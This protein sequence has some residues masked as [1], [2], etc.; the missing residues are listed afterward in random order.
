M[1]KTTC[2]YLSQINLAAPF[3]HTALRP[4]LV[5]TL[6]QLVQSM[7]RFSSLPFTSRLSSTTFYNPLFQHYVFHI[8]FINTDILEEGNLAE[9]PL[10][11]EWHQTSYGVHGRILTLLEFFLMTIDNTGKFPFTET[12]R[13]AMF[14][15]LKGLRLNR[16]VELIQR[17]I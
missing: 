3:N 2:P 5:S 15:T 14:W 9:C 7:P 8:S 10:T 4:I 16:D 12:K 1:F 11:T 17:F 13:Y 6:V